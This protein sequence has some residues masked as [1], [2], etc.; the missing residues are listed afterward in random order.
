MYRS[1]A[2]LIA[3]KATLGA[4]LALGFLAAP[5]GTAHAELTLVIQ[6]GDDNGDGPIDEDESGWDCATMGDQICGPGQSSP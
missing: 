2:I 5:H 4:A 1:T 6:V 3:A